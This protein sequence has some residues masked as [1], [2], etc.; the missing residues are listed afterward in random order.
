MIDANPNRGSQLAGFLINLG[1]DSELEATGSRGFLAAAEA[2]DVEL[3][4]IAYDL[5]QGWPLN[6]TLASLR[7]DA[8]TAAIPIFIYGPLNV[9]FNHPSVEQDYPGIR[10]LVQPVDAATL[11]R[12][13]KELPAPLGDAEH[14][15]YAREATQLLVQ[16]AK[17]RQ[18]PLASDL[19]AAEPALTAALHASETAPSAATVLADV[20]D[21]DAQRSLADAI[22]DPA[23]ADALRKQSAVELTR[24]IAR[25]GRLMSADQESRLASTLRDEDDP[26]IRASLLMIVRALTAAPRADVARPP[27]P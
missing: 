4:L 2:A 19:R 7:A 1:Y 10:F 15:A 5:F 21:P 18:G 3:I 8:R 23:S 16:I 17:D 22:L 25:F 6:A 27:K 20:P 12:Q 9:R 13:L 14:A 26:D 11:K 24:S